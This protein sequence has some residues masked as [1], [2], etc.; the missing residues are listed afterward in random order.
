LTAD[1]DALLDDL[2]AV[3]HGM[4]SL[5]LDRSAFDLERA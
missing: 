4:A 1:V 5:Y 2:R 3:L